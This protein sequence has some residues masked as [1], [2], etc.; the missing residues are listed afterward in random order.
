MGSDQKHTAR[1]CMCACIWVDKVGVEPVDELARISRPIV[2]ETESE[3]DVSVLLTILFRSMLSVALCVCFGLVSGAF[4]FTSDFPR[5]RLG[6]VRAERFMFEFAYLLPNGS[7]RHQ[8]RVLDK[9]CSVCV[10]QCGVAVK[11]Q[12]EM[13]NQLCGSCGTN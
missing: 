7:T 13:I 5:V 1:V 11:V 4:L 9:W 12:F 10:R 8:T 3:R 2:F 6:F